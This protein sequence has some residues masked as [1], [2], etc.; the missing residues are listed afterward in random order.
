[1]FEISPY[2]QF[3]MG[4]QTFGHVENQDRPGYIKNK[5]G[6]FSTGV[7]F[8]SQQLR[9]FFCKSPIRIIQFM[10]HFQKQAFKWDQS[11]K[12]VIAYQKVQPLKVLPVVS[13]RYVL[14]RIHKSELNLL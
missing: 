8:R 5:Q 4:F 13:N 2:A 9:D 3:S 10:L 1:M 12:T 14:L 11:L 7:Y 6:I